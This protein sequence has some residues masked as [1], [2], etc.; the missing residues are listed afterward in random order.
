MM[1]QSVNNTQPTFGMAL[2]KPN[3]VDMEKFA[4]VTKLADENF[5]VRSTAGR[6]LKQI[7]KENKNNPF[8]IIFNAA[9]EAFEVLSKNGIVLRA[10]PLKKTKV[11]EVGAEEAAKAVETKVKK[12]PSLAKQML[13]ALKVLVFEPKNIMP[14]ALKKA[15]NF[16]K[17]LHNTAIAEEKVAVAAQKRLDKAVLKTKDIFAGK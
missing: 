13:K 5:L 12:E 8:D 6:G 11:I 17:E 15:S 7:I 1:L 10:F 3:A 16:A 4:Q 14:S 2:R 9:E